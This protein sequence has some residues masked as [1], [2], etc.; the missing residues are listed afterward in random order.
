[1]MVAPAGTTVSSVVS[2]QLVSVKE[3]SMP[4]DLTRMMSLTGALAGGVGEPTVAAGEEPD[5]TIGL[6]LTEAAGDADAVGGR[7]LHESGANA[8]RQATPNRTPLRI[9]R[10]S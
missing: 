8:I 5:A 7:L 6:G 2:A 9:G 1:M 4:S 3:A 10:R